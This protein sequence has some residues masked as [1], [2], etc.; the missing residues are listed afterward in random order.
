MDRDVGAPVAGRLDRGAELLGREGRDVERAV[1]RGDAA[2]RGQLDLRGALHELLARR[3]R[4]SS[5]LS[6]TM[7]PPISSMRRRGPPMV[8]GRSESWRKSP[9]PLVTVIIAPEG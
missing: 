4:T 1:R 3:T 8:R 6:A 2:A 7:L 9:W 5:G